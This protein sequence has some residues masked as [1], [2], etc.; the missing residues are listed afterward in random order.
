MRAPSPAQSSYKRTTSAAALSV[1]LAR[2]ATSSPRPYPA[3][4]PSRT[5]TTQ[6]G[7]RADPAA[8]QRPLAC[9]GQ[10]ETVHAR[11]RTADAGPN[12]VQAVQVQA[13]LQRG[14][15]IGQVNVPLARNNDQFF[16]VRRFCHGPSAHPTHTSR[17][18][19]NLNRAQP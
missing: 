10:S 3:S 15:W 2:S 18:L 6:A 12:G 19:P 8:L 17:Y 4:G 14:S 9:G 11:L 13:K 5:Q 7:T 1:V 16:D